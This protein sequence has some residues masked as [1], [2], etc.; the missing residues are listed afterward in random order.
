M[1]KIAFLCSPGLDSFIKHIAED[2]SQHY[3]TNLVVTNELPEIVS[4]INNADII[5]L[6]WANELAIHVTTKLPDFLVGKKVIIRAHSYEALAGYIPQIAWNQVDVLICVADHIRDLI[7]SQWAIAQELGEFDIENFPVWTIPNGVDPEKFLFKERQKGFD[8]AYLG[9]IN[10]KKGPMLL[11]HAFQRLVQS[12][13]RY[14]LHIAGEFQEPRYDLYFQQMTKKLKLEK[15]IIRYGHIDNP[16]EWLDDK[17]Y[18]VNSS[19]LEGHPVGITEAM[20]MGIKPVVHNFFGAETL[21]RKE[22]LWST[23]SQFVSIV[24]SNKYDSHSYLN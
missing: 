20:C 14:K 16:Q 8:L 17:N 11:F 7:T 13:N 23:I 6:E 3:E 24:K 15:N 19:V 18:I 2:L 22:H 1:K 12:N 4:A 21:Y 10:F 5:W 9:H